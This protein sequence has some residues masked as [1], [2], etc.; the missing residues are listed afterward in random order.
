[1]FILTTVSGLGVVC[2]SSA[3]IARWVMVKP[4]IDPVPLYWILALLYGFLFA[5]VV[6]HGLVSL[7]HPRNLEFGDSAISIPSGFLRMQT[8]RLPYASILGFS[9]VR[10][11]ES[12]YLKLRTTIGEFSLLSYVSDNNSYDT[13]KRLFNQLLDR[14][15]NL[16]DALN[17]PRQI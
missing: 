10:F 16:N 11:G 14:R 2:W 8:T 12:Q 1:M 17:S 15:G 5:C 3:T 7:I 4:I 6:V 9:E 13:M